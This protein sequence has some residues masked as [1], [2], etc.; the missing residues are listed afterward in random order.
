MNTNIQK[1]RRTRHKRITRQTQCEEITSVLSNEILNEI[2]IYL[3]IREK[4]QAGLTCKRWYH[5]LHSPKL[6]KRID[7]S[8]KEPKAEMFPIF[9]DFDKY[10]I[11]FDC[12][13]N[14]LFSVKKWG[15]S[16]SSLNLKCCVNINEFS[17]L[18][19]LTFSTQS[20]KELN[21]SFLDDITTKWTYR[22][23]IYFHNIHTLHLESSFNL[24]DDSVDLIAKNLSFLEN[25]FLDDCFLLTDSG[26]KQICR[27]CNKRLKK[28]S[29]N[30]CYL[31]TEQILLYLTNCVNLRYLNIGNTQKFQF[32]NPHQEN[33][34]ESSFEEK[35]K[36]NKEK[37]RE[38]NQAKK[39]QIGNPKLN[40]NFNEAM[41][42]VS[43]ESNEM[44]TEQESEGDSYL[45][46]LAQNFGLFCKNLT[47]LDL[48]NHTEIDDEILHHM[49][50]PMNALETII[51][52]ECDIT[53]STLAFLS[54]KNT[55][56]RKLSVQSVSEISQEG[57]S[58]L[59]SNIPD[60]CILNMNENEDLTDE[61]FK[62]LEDEDSEIFSHLERLRISSSKISDEGMKFFLDFE[63][64]KGFQSNIRELDF[65]C[66]TSIT[67][68][69]LIKLSENFWNLEAISVAGCDVTDV[70]VS[71]FAAKSPKIVVF[72]A[73]GCRKIGTKGVSCLFE[74]CNRVV[75]VALSETQIEDEVLNSIQK[76]SR[77]L[78]FLNI[79]YCES[80][81]DEGLFSLSNC[82]SPLEWIDCRGCRGFTTKGVDE[83][84]K[85]CLKI[86]MINVRE[87]GELDPLI[88]NKMKKRAKRIGIDM[89]IWLQ[90]NLI[91]SLSSQTESTFSSSNNLD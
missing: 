3:N 51:L 77:N 83:V 21:I 54:E 86:Q 10:P 91:S 90:E 30:S 52:D 35:E 57:I 76:F 14:V 24:D 15:K 64:R 7:F 82:A 43:T 63:T 39:R 36:D 70:G 78:R 12:N 34:Y 29:L 53:D 74:N 42:I 79:S 60:L 87:I 27:H 46:E 56:L 6:W 16:I 40:R 62:F 22:K 41:E 38:K 9:R 28:L 89:T 65:E 61:I 48:S 11:Q 72:D 45:I 66:C 68:Q 59:V 50:Q 47:F 2:F 32:K 75:A 4:I 33:S 37:K 8:A 5:C 1:R 55:N 17:I 19:F 81:T 23:L 67:D 58:L 13:P 73:D 88:L 31:I 71:A 44:D 80:L 18:N 85:K 84:T 49:I 20:L 25:I 26:V 69:T